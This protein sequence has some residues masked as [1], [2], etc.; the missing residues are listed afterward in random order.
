MRVRD[1]IDFDPRTFT[2]ANI[3]RSRHDGIELD[4]SLFDSAPVAVS[5]NYAWS[6]TRPDHANTQLK[7]IPRHLF[8]PEVTLNLPAAATVHLRYTSTAGRFADDD[9]Q[10]A[11]RRRS[12]IDLRAAKRL[13][14]V[15]VLVDVF[16][17]GNAR[18][19]EVGFVLP[20]VRGGLT[21]FFYPAPGISATAGIELTF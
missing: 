1:E 17:L 16:N 20:D 7:N 11:L 15:R 8:R 6:H 4:A 14:R 9:N 10:T 18:Y 3:G 2:Y 12:T 5:V 21:P 19:E 13:S